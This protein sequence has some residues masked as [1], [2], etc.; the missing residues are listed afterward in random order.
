[1]PNF[2]LHSSEY[3]ALSEWLEL[4]CKSDATKLNTRFFV[5]LISVHSGNQ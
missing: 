4:G 5:L 2:A 3:S 1:M